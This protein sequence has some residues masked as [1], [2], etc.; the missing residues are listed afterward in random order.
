MEDDQAIQDMIDKG[1]NRWLV[2]NTG[3]DPEVGGRELE[4]DAFLHGVYFG[5]LLVKRL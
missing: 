1:F 5:L 2:D 3:E 4:Y